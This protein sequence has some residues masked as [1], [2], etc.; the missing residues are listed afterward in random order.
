[1]LSLI[2]EIH[3]STP[4]GAA[5]PRHPCRRILFLSVGAKPHT[6]AW[7]TSPLSSSCLPSPLTCTYLQIATRAFQ[8]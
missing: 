5:G 1:M 6:A 4:A 8:E 7:T 2:G 3:S